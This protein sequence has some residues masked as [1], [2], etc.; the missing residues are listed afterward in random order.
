[1]YIKLYFVF[2]APSVETISFKVVYCN[3]K[4]M[5][6]ICVS[7]NLN[8]DKIHCSDSDLVSTNNKVPIKR[9]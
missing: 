8:K 9:I 3:G 7:D 5:Y 1:M 4:V 2:K 6:L